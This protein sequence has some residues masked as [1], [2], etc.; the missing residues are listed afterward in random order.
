VP[1]KKSQIS[2]PKFGDDYKFKWVTPAKNFEKYGK[3]KIKIVQD[4]DAHKHHRNH[5]LNIFFAQ[6]NEFI[7]ILFKHQK[8]SKEQSKLNIN[9]AIGVAKALGMR[10]NKETFSEA[11]LKNKEMMG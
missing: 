7:R 4:I 10:V 9:Y 6:Y 3:T 5:K 11:N 8:A 2:R 1:K